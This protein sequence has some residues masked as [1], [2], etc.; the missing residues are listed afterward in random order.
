MSIAG[1]D[2]VYAAGHGY[3]DTDTIVFYNGTPPSPL[4]EGT[5][6]YVR[7]ADSDTFK[8]AATSGGTAIDLTS[9][10]SYNCS[11]CAITEEVYAAADTHALSS[12]TVS[13]PD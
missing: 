11:V 10:P 9:A 2:T 8:V 13:I 1:T 7:D 12:A 6:Y 3:T 5:V 4:V